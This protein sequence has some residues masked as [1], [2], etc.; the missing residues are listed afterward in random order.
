MRTCLVIELRSRA[1]VCHAKQLY[2]GE[3]FEF[4][5][6]E[7]ASLGSTG[8]L[9]LE[10]GGSGGCRIVIRTLGPCFKVIEGARLGSG[11]K[12]IDV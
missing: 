5:G 8:I 2:P 1:V 6:I 3:P 11:G 9:N 12:E 7:D 10:V 4:I